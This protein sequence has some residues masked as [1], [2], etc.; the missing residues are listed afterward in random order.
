MTDDR[1]D[2]ARAH[3]DRALVEEM[4][5]EARPSA[6]GGSGGGDLARDVGSRD[7]MNAVADPDGHE[8][9]TGEDAANAGVAEAPNRES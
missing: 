1:T 5:D 9:V 3:D 7:D 2:T 6:V 8:R 4:E